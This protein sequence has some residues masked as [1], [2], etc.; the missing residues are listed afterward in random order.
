ML[1][2]LALLVVGSVQ[3]A[4]WYNV[5]LLDASTGRP[6]SEFLQLYGPPRSSVPFTSGPSTS[7]LD[8][9]SRKLRSGMITTLEAG[10]DHLFPGR[11]SRAESVFSSG[12][13][14]AIVGPRP[15]KGG[16]SSIFLEDAADAGPLII[17]E[18]FVRFSYRSAPARTSQT[19]ITSGEI[20]EMKRARLTW[21]TVRQAIGFQGEVYISSSFP[22]ANE[23]RRDEASGSSVEES[24]ARFVLVGRSK[25]GND[26]V[27]SVEDPD[28][29]YLLAEITR[30]PFVDPNTG[31]RANKVSV[32]IGRNPRS[33]DMLAVTS[34]SIKSPGA[35]PARFANERNVILWSDVQKRLSTGDLE[36]VR[37]LP[38]RR[39]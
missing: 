23:V 5:G 31:L 4:D 33:L 12:E 19:R 39:L 11:N 35:I 1:Q 10:F 26:V 15:G 13:L 34:V 28:G 7:S 21:G 25:A 30:T 16:T 27:V 29:D 37:K 18:T 36:G 17:Q 8:Y 24:W 14:R 6:S 20:A 9:G 32:D 22:I 38:V 3:G 2:V